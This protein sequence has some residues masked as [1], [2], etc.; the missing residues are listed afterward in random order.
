MSKKTFTDADKGVQ[1]SF[2]SDNFITVT[3]V[4]FIFK[5]FQTAFKKKNR[6]RKY[7]NR[8]EMKL[9]EFLL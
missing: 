1:N 6:N 5:N 2:L 3:C 4:R 7:E 8:K 9:V